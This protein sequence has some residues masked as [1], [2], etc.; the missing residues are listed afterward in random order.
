MPS[1]RRTIPGLLATILA[2]STVALAQSFV[3]VTSQPSG[4]SSP[5]TTSRIPQTTYVD[6]GKGDHTFRPETIQAAIGDIITFRFY[7]VNHSV[8]RADYLRY[9]SCSSLGLEFLVMLQSLNINPTVHA[10]HTS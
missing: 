6:V 7:P 3:T 4:S 2:F 10:Y 9:F 1:Q 5:T 8:V